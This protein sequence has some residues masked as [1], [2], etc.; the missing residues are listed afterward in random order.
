[1]LVNT[2]MGKLCGLFQHRGQTP[3]VIIIAQTN[4][5]RIPLQATN[6]PTSSTICALSE[7]GTCTLFQVRP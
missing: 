3:H 6:L 5:F 2:Q 1:M 7:I 4:P